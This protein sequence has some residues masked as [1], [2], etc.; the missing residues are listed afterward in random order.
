[1]VFTTSPSGEVTRRTHVI[2]DDDD[3]NNN[4]NNNTTAT[5]ENITMS[6]ALL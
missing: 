6:V 2:R 3:N 5:T 4:S 1:V